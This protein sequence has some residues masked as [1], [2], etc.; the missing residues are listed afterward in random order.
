M[1]YVLRTYGLTKRYG[2]TSVVANVSMNIRRGDIYGF[3]GRNGAGK[4]T[5]MRLICGLINKS[6]GA[7]ELFGVKDDE[8]GINVARRRTGAIIETPSVY[9]E[10][11]A[12]QNLKEQCLALGVAAEKVIP[13]LLAYVGL[14]NTGSKKARNFSLGMRQRLGIAMALAGSPDFII[15][16]EPVNGLDPQGIVEI[17]ELLLRLN[18]EKNITILISSHILGE[19]SKLATCYGFIEKGNLIKE[20]TAAELEDACRK[21][22]RIVVGNT[23]KLA[24]VLERGLGIENFKILSDTEAEI[25]GE[26]KIGELAAALNAAGISLERVHEKDEDLEGYFLNLVGGGRN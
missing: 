11:T 26:V 4:T 19:L 6:E 8:K 21:S 7:Y 5:L 9:P 24:Y 17:R 14:E 12:F 20:I 18:R 23:D 2:K 3:V 16:D 10:M 13:G 22:V 1:E 15:L 25:Y